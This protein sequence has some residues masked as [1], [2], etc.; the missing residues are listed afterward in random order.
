MSTKTILLLLLLI[1]CL[2]CKKVDRDIDGSNT[3]SS[4][5]THGI[6]LIDSVAILL[7]NLNKLN[8]DS[9][10]FAKG[11]SQINQAISKILEEVSNPKILIDFTKIDDLDEGLSLS[12]TQD[13]SMAILSWDSRL[14]GSSPEIK[15]VALLQNNQKIKSFPLHGLSARFTDI[16]I[17]NQQSQAPIYIFKGNGRSSGIEGYVTLHAYRFKNGLSKALIF[18]N[19]K[20]SITIEYTLGNTIDFIVSNDASKIFIPNKTYPNNDWG[21]IYSVL[22]FDGENYHQQTSQIDFPLSSESFNGPNNYDNGYL[23][24]SE[25]PIDTTQKENLTSFTL[26]FKDSI[27]IE[28]NY[29][30]EEET[31]LLKIMAKNDK[32]PIVLS[33]KSYDARLWA[34]QKQY[35]FVGL[36][37]TSSHSPLLVYDINKQEYITSIS[38]AGIKLHNEAVLVAQPLAKNN[39]GEKPKCV[40]NYGDQTAYFQTFILEYR[41]EYPTIMPTGQQFC[42]FSE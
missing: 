41:S 13:T 36:S 16:F 38:Q 32:T 4:S 22:S 5:L 37:G 29:D 23:E 31:T 15:S 28:R 30:P 35:L 3:K 26:V 25:I 39:I 14:G 40:T 7:H 20:S 21:L 2:Q 10:N 1:P 42:G 17:L 33:F 8:V 9:T 24:G 34:K 27:Q 12:M 6:E 11:A 19:N 18:P